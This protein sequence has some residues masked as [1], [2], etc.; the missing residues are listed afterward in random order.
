MRP[1]G[2][3]FDMLDLE[4]PII[5]NFLPKYFPQTWLLTHPSGKSGAF[6]IHS[7]C[8]ECF[9][10]CFSF[11]LPGAGYPFPL[12]VSKCASHCVSCCVGKRPLNSQAVM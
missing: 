10:S 12:F 1:M 7:K 2:P 9:F 5:T 6:C 4:H 11:F 8:N 3:E